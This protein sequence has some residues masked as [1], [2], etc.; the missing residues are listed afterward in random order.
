MP[1]IEAFMWVIGCIVCWLAFLS[2]VII[3]IGYCD[4][5]K[6]DD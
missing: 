1:M 5:K 2:V 4:K 6:G 3:Y